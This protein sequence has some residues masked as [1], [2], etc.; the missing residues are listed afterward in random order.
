MKMA[1]DGRG[2]GLIDN[3]ASHGSNR[4]SEHERALGETSHTSTSCKPRS[5]NLRRVRRSER[6]T[7]IQPVRLSREC[8]AG[9]PGTLGITV[10][11]NK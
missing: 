1:R 5:R 11:G 8:R 7:G 3:I 2:A 4:L 6:R 10:A 9:L